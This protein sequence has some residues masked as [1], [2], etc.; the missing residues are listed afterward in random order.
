M[1]EISVTG[2]SSD[3]ITPGIFAE[4]LFGAGVNAGSTQTYSA[5]ILGNKLSSGTASDAT[6]YG[7][8]DFSDRA[9]AVQLFGDGSEV[10]RMVDKF[11]AVNISTPLYA[12]PVAQAGTAGDGY[13]NFSGTA[14]GNGSVEICV[15]DL[16]MQ[17]SI[18]SGDS[19]ATIATNAAAVV[20]SHSELPCTAIVV[21]NGMWLVSKN[22]GARANFIRFR[23]RILGIGVGVSSS[24]TTDTAFTHGA[25]N[26]D[27]SNALAAMI[28]TRFYYIISPHVDATNLGLIKAQ[29]E[30][31]AQPLVNIHQRVVGGSVDSL[32]AITTIANGINS[33][34][35]EFVWHKNSE[36]TPGEL[37]SLGAANF[38]LQEQKLGA[39]GEAVNFDNYGLSVSNAALWRLPRDRSNTQ[40]TAANILSAL[41]SG[42][43]PVATTSLGQTYLVMGCTSH[44]LNGANPDYRVRDRH[45]VT[46]CDRFTD[47]C[48]QAFRDKFPQKTLGEDKPA[49]SFSPVDEVSPRI[50]VEAVN[51]ITELYG[52]R[53]LLRNV[54]EIRA[55][56]VGSLSQTPG[57][58]GVAVPLQVCQP[59]HQIAFQVKQVA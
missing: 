10:M 34:R 38:S 48:I 14:T 22:T 46:V 15:A 1:A 18:A 41:K 9:T 20:N 24:A 32:G 5:I 40:I 58:V 2:L 55:G 11:W 28:A 53:G 54:D 12:C 52:Q 30:N 35:C 23:G 29:V 21:G 57:R 59:L 42:I 16:V 31:Q 45:I 6:V 27:V 7:P 33:P 3:N 17:S 26:D 13:I 44:S 49:G 56:T 51:Q 8:N 39:S 50:I 43:S 19:L 36:F 4:V 47:D 25:T 37:A